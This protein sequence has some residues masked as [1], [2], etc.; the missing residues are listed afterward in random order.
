MKN[1][2]ASFTYPSSWIMQIESI[3][4]YRTPSIRVTVTASWKVFGSLSQRKPWHLD[5]YVSEVVLKVFSVPQQ[6]LKAT[7]SPKKFPS[8]SNRK[9]SRPGLTSITLR[10]SLCCGDWHRWWEFWQ[11][12][13]HFRAR[14]SWN[15]GGV[16]TRSDNP[17]V[18]NEIIIKQWME[19]VL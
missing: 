9:G 15:S 18:V 7:H 3:H 4:K 14:L 11:S 1:D 19:T 6:W 5:A 17:T 12:W 16:G 8:V 10:G 13:S 2:R